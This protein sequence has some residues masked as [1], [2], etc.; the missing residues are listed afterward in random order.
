MSTYYYFKCNKCNRK[1][2]FYSRQAWG[3]GNF[4]II[5]SFKF[6]AFHT[7]QCGEEYIRVISE[8]ND[9]YE[10]DLNTETLEFYKR[11]SYE[12][13]P[14]SNDWGFMMDVKEKGIDELNEAWVTER[15]KG[16]KPDNGIKIRGTITA[17]E[18]EEK[19][20]GY[21][22][23]AYFL[24]EDEKEYTF[25]DFD[26]VLPQ[27]GTKYFILGEIVNSEIIEKVN[28]GEIK[29]TLITTRDMK[30]LVDSK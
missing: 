8:H 28:V 7:D 3:W 12:N 6:L 13:F 16:I 18:Y 29:G 1:G 2:G 11:D 26:K 27:I 5:E 14:L 9:D 19:K 17:I 22:Y 15:I 25:I 24:S 10:E 4:D 21:A 20:R 30:L 23:K